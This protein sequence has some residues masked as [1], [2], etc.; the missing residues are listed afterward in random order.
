MDLRWA[1]G[2][3]TTALLS[4]FGYAL[5]AA[6]DFDQQMIILRRDVVDLQRRVE[7][8]DGDLASNRLTRMAPETRT[9]L[10]AIRRELDSADRRLSTLEEKTGRR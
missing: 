8:I 3:A 1:A 9:E 5:T 10:D 7:R 2:I 6:R 4:A